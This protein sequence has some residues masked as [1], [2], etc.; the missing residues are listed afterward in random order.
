MTSGYIIVKILLFVFLS[1]QSKVIE[2][3]IYS[4]LYTEVILGHFEEFFRKSDLSYL[5]R[6]KKVGNFIDWGAKAVTQLIEKSKVGCPFDVRL[7]VKK[8]PNFGIF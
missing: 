1:G 5:L 7:K 6:P 2:V 3:Q 4:I 8:A